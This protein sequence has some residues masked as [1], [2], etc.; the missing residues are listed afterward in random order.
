M[1]LVTQTVNTARLLPGILESLS[2]PVGRSDLTNKRKIQP[3][4]YSLTRSPTTYHQLIT[5]KESLS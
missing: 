1:L 4:I 2:P 5:S 3:V